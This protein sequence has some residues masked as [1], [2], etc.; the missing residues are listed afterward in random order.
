MLI[1]AGLGLWDEKDLSVKTLEAIRG[2]DH[3]YAEFYTSTL[4]GADRGRMETIYG[5]PITE[6]RREEIE[7]DPG[8]LLE[9]AKRGTVVL[10]VGGDPMVATTHIDL[11][12]R[13]QERGIPV[14][15]LHGA[16][17]A[18]ATPGLLGLQ[19]YKFGRSGT[20]SRPYSLPLE[21]RS[22]SG[23]GVGRGWVPGDAYR[24]A[25]DNHGRG[26][27]TLLLLDLGMAIPEALGLLARAE[28]NEGGGLMDL[29][30]AGVARAGSPEPA[31]HA[32]TPQQLARFDFGPTPHVLVL[33]GS[34]HFM[35]AE[36]LRTLAGAPPEL[37]PREKP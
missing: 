27:H 6:L 37:L 15:I 17:I 30:W 25:R 22:P 7:N 35:E 20:V 18:G 31:V 5:R 33:P 29:L 21:R 32:D 11:R 4:P 16:S 14:C 12:L 3:I 2:A 36:A 1:F 13:A 26:L 8:P 24:A 28:E 23:S 9:R 19:S 10:L 34:L